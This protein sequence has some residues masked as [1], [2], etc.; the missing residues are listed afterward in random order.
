MNKTLT[1]LMAGLLAP[2]WSAVAAQEQGT[3]PLIDGTEIRSIYSRSASLPDGV[4][5]SVTVASVTSIADDDPEYANA[6]I[7]REM[8]LDESESDQFI[9]LLRAARENLEAD[10]QRRFEEIACIT[11][12]PRV[13]GDNTY[14]VLE[15]MDDEADLIAET[16]YQ[17]FM[18]QIDEDNRERLQAWIDKQKQHIVHKKFDQEI[19]SRKVGVDGYERLE[20][21]CRL[22][23]ANFN[24]GK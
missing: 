12:I 11:G 4:A 18:N 7:Q 3:T 5:F 16:H 17:R 2:F 24:G 9:A 1:I 20:R 21:I 15:Q 6:W 8:G 22:L 10:Q 23:N 14:A 13:Y 19:R